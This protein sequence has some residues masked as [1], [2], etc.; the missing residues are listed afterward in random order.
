MDQRITSAMERH[1]EGVT[2][3]YLQ[4][5]TLSGYDK[6]VET[7]GCSRDEALCTIIDWTVELLDHLDEYEKAYAHRW[8]VDEILSEQFFDFLDEFIETKIKE[9][10]FS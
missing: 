2:I 10:S 4:K 7:F 1:G 9:T 6:V 8:G 3:Y 5:M